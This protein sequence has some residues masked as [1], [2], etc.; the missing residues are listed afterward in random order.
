MS[1]GSR[2]RLN[3]QQSIN[4]GVPFGDRRG[5][6]SASA[7]GAWVPDPGHLAG[8]R[9]RWQPDPGNRPAPRS[10][11]GRREKAIRHPV[12]HKPFTGK[13]PPPNPNPNPKTTTKQTRAVPWDAPHPARCCGSVVALPNRT[14]GAELRKQTHLPR[15]S[16]ALPFPPW[17][18]AGHH[19]GLRA[20]AGRRFARPRSGSAGNASRGSRVRHG[21]GAG[22]RWSQNNPPLLT[23]MTPRCRVTS[24]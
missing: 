14:G 2:Q 10:H 13:P 7:P 4:N 19:G 15:A 9:S 6:A 17:G 11:R 22:G 18:F 8:R 20:G 1:S 21:R 3:Y 23:S 16:S 12:G 5:A 24:S